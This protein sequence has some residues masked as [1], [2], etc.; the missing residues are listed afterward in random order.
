MSLLGLV[1][2]CLLGVLALGKGGHRFLNPR[3]GRIGIFS[4][5]DD[6]FSFRCQVTVQKFAHQ[7]GD[8]LSVLLQGK[9]TGVEQV[10]IDILEIPLVGFGA[11][12][13]EDIVVLSPGNQ[14]RWLV[15][16]KV[17]LPLGIQRRVGSVA[18]EKLDLDVLVAGSIQQKLV[19]EP[20]VWAIVSTSRTPCV[21]CH[22]V[23]SSVSK[24]SRRTCAF[25]PVFSFQYILIG[26]Q[27]SYR[28]SS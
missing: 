17:G 15:A 23:A 16:S 26:F 5:G 12:T 11:F 27:N 14:R 6:G 24:E 7:V 9:V 21:Y 4:P 3:P 19:V 28:P 18:V 25:C 2:S 13:G 20:I 8:D 1:M 22:F 10:E